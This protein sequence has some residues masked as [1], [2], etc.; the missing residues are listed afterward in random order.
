MASRKRGL[1]SNVRTRTVSTG[2]AAMRFDY[3][4]GQIR[5]NP[6]SEKIHPSDSHLP[7]AFIVTLAKS[8]VRSA[9]W[10]LP[11]KPHFCR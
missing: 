4:G 2:E 5:V 10:P 6:K 8:H 1:M 7:E 11:R 9:V 3:K